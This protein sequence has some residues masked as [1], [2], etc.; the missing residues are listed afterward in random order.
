MPVA[1]DP[2]AY[3]SALE[4]I[5][6][7]DS[8]SRSAELR[9]PVTLVAAENDAVASP[10]VMREWAARLPRARFVCLPG[11]AHMSPFVQPE[12]LLALMRAHVEFRT[13]A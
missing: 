1:A 8:S 6:T 11:A 2:L 3:A 9:M 10:A 5:A 12:N 4:A 7:Y 13:R